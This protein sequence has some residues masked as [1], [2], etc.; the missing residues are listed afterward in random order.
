MRFN[1]GKGILGLALVGACL[2]VSP[3]LADVQLPSVVS[4]GMVLQR[5]AKVPIWGWADPGEKVKVTFSGQSVAGKADKAGNWKVYLQP[6]TASATPAEMVIKGKNSITLNDI[7]VGDV[8]ICAGQSNMQF[9]TIAG[10]NGQQEMANANYPSIRLYQLPMIS[11]LTPLKDN[12]TAW[13]KCSAGPLAWFSAVGYFFGRSLYKHLNI[14]I[15]L[16]D[17]AIGGTRAEA[18]TSIEALT[19]K[20]HFKFEA[21]ELKKAVDAN[22]N[23]TYIASSCYNAMCV[24]IIPFAAKGVIWYQGESNAGAA[25]QYTELLNTMIK[26]WRTKWENKDMPFL[27]VQ[28]AN[29]LA[30]PAEPGQSTWAE[31]REAQVNVLKTKNTGIALAIDIGDAVDIHPKNKQDVGYRLYLAARKIA[32]GEDLVYSGPMYKSMSKHGNK[33]VVKFD[34]VAKGLV[35]RGGELKQFA[36]A[37]ED[38]K[39]YWAKATIE[40]KDVVVSSDKVEK[41]VAVRYAW[42]DNPDGCN[43]YNSENLPASPFRTDK[44]PGITAGFAKK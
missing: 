33:I 40:G 27:I 9:G 44:W 28:L 34:H 42:A 25:G 11:S 35:A 6:M 12:K 8:W 17:N 2:A 30:P 38:Q 36:I 31:L 21:G 29:F 41:P 10:I 15:G 3:V 14:P 19:A 23:I 32:Y 20:P 37:G 5:E 13:A 4:S 26:D 7:L 43:L 24:P 39:F 22:N 16:I 18:W 1:F